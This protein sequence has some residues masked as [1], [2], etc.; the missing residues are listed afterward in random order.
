[1]YAYIHVC[2]YTCMHY[3]EARNVYKVQIVTNTLVLCLFP[4]Q[5]SPP[6][7]AGQ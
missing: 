5:R 2:I 7:G 1:M 3:N 4:V 6:G